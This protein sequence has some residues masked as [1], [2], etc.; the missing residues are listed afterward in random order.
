MMLI[1][2]SVAVRLCD[3]IITAICKQHWQMQYVPGLLTAAESTVDSD[4]QFVCL[5]LAYVYIFPIQ[6]CEGIFMDKT[7]HCFSF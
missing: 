5:F 7:Q 1:V 6:T 3:N 4:A 2:W